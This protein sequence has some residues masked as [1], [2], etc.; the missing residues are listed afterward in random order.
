[1][2][3]EASEKKACYF[4][5]LLSNGEIAFAPDAEGMLGYTNEDY[6]AKNLHAFDGIVVRSGRRSGLCRGMRGRLFPFGSFT[7]QEGS[8]LF[9]WWQSLE[10]EQGFFESECTYE[11]GS[12]IRSRGFI[13]PD[14]NIYALCKTF[15]VAGGENTFSYEVRLAGYNADISR[16]MQILYTGE[17][18][19]VG[20]IGFRMFG[21]E[22]YRGEIQ[23]FVDKDFT[24][25]ALDD[26]V[27]LTFNATDGETVHFYYCLEDDSNGTDFSAVL[28]R[29]RRKIAQEGFDGLLAQCRQHFG[30]YYDL[31]Y[32]RTDNETFNNIY[33]TSLY[34]VK[35]NAT[36]H[37]V[38]VGF[39]NGSWD[40][41][42]FAFDE[43]TSY[44]GLLGANR[45]ALAKRIPEYR[46][47][48]CLPNAIMRGSDCHRTAE[49]EDTAFFHW[50][51]GEVDEYE[52]STE[53]NW[54][55]HIFHIPMIGIGA[56]NYYEYSGDRTFLEEYYPMIRACAKFIT[57]HMVYRDGDSLYIGKC[58]DLER[59]G[60][61][62]ENP[63][64]TA[65]GAIKLL[66]SCAEAAETLKTDLA[67]AAECK[68]TAQKLT[69]NLPR[70]GDMYV[71]FRGCK[72]KSIAMF[73][74]KFPFDV[75]P[76]DD[77]KMLKAWEDFEINGAA[78]G[79]MYPTGRGI[80]PWYACWKAAAYARA[81]LTDKA[82]RA[83]IQAYPSAGVFGEMFEINEEFTMRLR[84]WFAT[85]AGIFVLASNEMFLQSEGKTIRIMPAFPHNKDASFK[86]AAKGGVTVEAQ[87]KDG[88]LVKALVLKDGRDVTDQFEIIF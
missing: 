82:Y 60:A 31:G 47:N 7:F 23:V 27:R 68:E 59:L 87:V 66:H 15:T 3:Y 52:V 25:T 19:N 20:C 5:P 86:L 46:K 12:R 78:Y 17:R 75:L 37:S 18:E 74:C 62:I 84:P 34:S 64:M 4:P 36:R 28:A 30:A 55:S 83:L 32:I 76:A 72:Q 26:G 49:T 61:S 42:Y 51:T 44:T 54:Q 22:V 39:N 8:A 77:E 63:F 35:S 58:T 56:W 38:A 21:M 81:G 67:Y 13:H 16:Y 9:D 29:Y 1:M 69:E 40:G 24:V 85:A 79:N 71:P 50:V 11:S 80:S 10:V 14:C 43:F 70:E 73:A 48:V 6:R 88:K 33:K 53:G 2:R 65:C 57:R 41:K 45:L